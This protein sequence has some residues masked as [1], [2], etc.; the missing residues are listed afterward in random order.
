[1][2]RAYPGAGSSIG[3]AFTF[4]FVAAQHAIASAADNT[5]PSG[6]AAPRVG[7]QALPA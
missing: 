5:K 1:M 7:S 3:P 2:G 4:G 6:D